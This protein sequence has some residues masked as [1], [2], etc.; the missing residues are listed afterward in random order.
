MSIQRVGSMNS[1]VDGSQWQGSG[2]SSNRE[3]LS[4]KTTYRDSLSNQV[5]SGKSLSSNMTN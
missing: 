2:T 1:T 3:T 4:N 5:T